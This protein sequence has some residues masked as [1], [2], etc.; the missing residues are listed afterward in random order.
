MQFGKILIQ[1]DNQGIYKLGHK[2]FL[3]KLFQQ[4]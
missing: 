2:L 4:I 3:L 1:A